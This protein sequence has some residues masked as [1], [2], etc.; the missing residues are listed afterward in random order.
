MIMERVMI[1]ERNSFQV[2][3]DESNNAYIAELID[4]L[5]ENLAR[6][7][8]FFN[9]TGLT[10]KINIRI[11]NSTEEYA[12]YLKPHIGDY[13]RWIVADTYN[14]DINILSYPLYLQGDGKEKCNMDDYKKVIIHE[15]V[16]ACQRA[17]NPQ[18]KDVFWFWEALATN[19]AWQ[20][21]YLM[22][23]PYTMAE[24]SSNFINLHHCYSAAYTIGRYLLENYTH[25]RLLGY[26]RNPSYLISD[27]ETIWKEARSWVQ[28]K[29]V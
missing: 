16:H 24:L 17:V 11:W 19:L 13:R 3:Y 27:A 14:G 9:L 25:E 5:D 4:V 8:G 28:T 22:D 21:F 2:I 23:I 15:L 10:K 1:T 29:T 18:A 12:R 7:M 26:V 20:R 6:I